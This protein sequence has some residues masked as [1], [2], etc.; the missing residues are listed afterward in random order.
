VSTAVPGEPLLAHDVVAGAAAR[1]DV[2]VFAHGI[3]GSRNNWKSFA[4]KVVAACPTWT[5]LLVDLRN[6]GQS[7]GQAPPHT[8]AAAADDVAALCRHLGVRP[9]AVV[10]HSWGGKAM[11]ELALRP[12]GPAPSDNDGVD[13]AVIVDAPPGTRTFGQHKEEID[14]VVAAIRAVPLPV[15]SRKALVEQLRAAG[16]SEPVAQWM[17]TNLEPTSSP[18]G[19]AGDGGLR[20][21][22]QLDAIPAMLADFGALDLWPALRAHAATGELPDVVF[23]RGGR[24]DRWSA[25]ETERLRT[26][27]AD[28]VVVDHVLPF[29]G[30]WVHTDDPAGLLA[31]VVPLLDAHA[32]AARGSAG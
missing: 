24:S 13:L 2:V 27:V 7:R 31:I 4:Q 20:W 8:V 29:A 3:L 10:G 5:A 32:S 26:A 1:D 28:G 21:K 16:L 12:R 17:T 22:F 6:H 11:L 9:R 30:H 25:D 15:P 19:A 18:D 14:R 23:V